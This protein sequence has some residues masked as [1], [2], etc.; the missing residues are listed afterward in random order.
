MEPVWRVSVGRI[1]VTGSFPSLSA[2][3]TTVTDDKAMAAPAIMGESSMPKT[4]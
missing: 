3:V 4:G 2:L 1:G